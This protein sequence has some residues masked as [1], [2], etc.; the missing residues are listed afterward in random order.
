MMNSFSA[1]IPVRITDI[2]YGNHL[3]HVAMVG[4]FHQARVLFLKAGGFS[5]SN[6]DQK[7]LIL[8]GAEYRY[9]K[10]SFFDDR[11]LFHVTVGELSRAQVELLYWVVD[12]SSNQEVVRGKERFMVQ[13]YQ[14]KK[15]VRLPE[16]FVAFCQ[17]HQ[18]QDSNL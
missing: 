4:L 16:A 6:I 12:A 9:K 1:L 3:S 15:V 7:G 5:E 10:E 18:T 11:L 13:D 14:R 2:N 17:A 8:S